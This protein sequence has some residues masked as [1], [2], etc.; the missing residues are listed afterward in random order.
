MLTA[1]SGGK[2]VH[3]IFES[4]RYLLAL[5]VPK[6]MKYAEDMSWI[7]LA[8]SNGDSAAWVPTARGRTALMW[9]VRGKPKVA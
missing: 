9:R 4:L 3:V 6:I 5:G 7:L 8:A 2:T 1:L